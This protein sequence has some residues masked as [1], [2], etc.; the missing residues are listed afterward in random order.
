M[1]PNR[2]IPVTLGDRTII[3]QRYFNSPG[4]KPSHQD[5]VNWFQHKYGRQLSQSVISRTLSKEWKHLDEDT[6]PIPGKIRQKQGKWPRLEQALFEWQQYVQDQQASITNLTLLTQAKRLWDRMD[7]YKDLPRP[8]FSN[9]WIIGFNKRH[10]IRNYRQHGESGSVDTKLAEE[11]MAKIRAKIKRYP[12]DCVY[13][14]D[15]TALFWRRGASNTQATSTQA[16]KL[17]I[18]LLI[19][20]YTN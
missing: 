20:I 16:G 1:P 15:E 3:R 10:N 14:M 18:L 17:N 11:K 7:E 4:P 9:G 2:R 13:N 5:L 12:L 6:S 8:K 19:L